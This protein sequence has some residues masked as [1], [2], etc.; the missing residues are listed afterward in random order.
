MSLQ[1]NAVGRIVVTDSNK[2]ALLEFSNSNF[3]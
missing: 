3:G 2:A 1:P